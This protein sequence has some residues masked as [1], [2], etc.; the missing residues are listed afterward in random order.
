MLLRHLWDFVACYRVNFTFTFTYYAS[1]GV[2][3]G[4]QRMAL[5]E[6]Y[7]LAV[8]KKATCSVITSVTLLPTAYRSRSFKY[9]YYRTGLNISSVR[10][11]TTVLSAC[12]P[13]HCYFLTYGW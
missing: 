11:V 13:I 4:A 12:I 7:S 5:G 10:I 8:N 1:R 6:L 2:I 3:L 9:M